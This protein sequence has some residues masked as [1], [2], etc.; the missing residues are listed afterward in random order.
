ME[1]LGHSRRHY[2]FGD[3]SPFFKQAGRPSLV[4]AS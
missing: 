4:T 1:D 3:L 2:I